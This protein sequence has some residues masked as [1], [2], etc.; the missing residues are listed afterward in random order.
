MFHEKYQE[1]TWARQD[2]ISSSSRA[3]ACG[4]RAVLIEKFWEAFLTLHTEGKRLP[5]NLEILFTCFTIQLH[6]KLLGANNG[7]SFY[8]LTRGM[9]CKAF[10]PFSGPFPLRADVVFYGISWE[11]DTKVK[12]S[13]TK[14]PSV[15]INKAV[16]F[17]QPIAFAVI[18]TLERSPLP[19][20]PLFQTMF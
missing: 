18:C 11:M 2:S 8:L 13:V 16:L 15:V 9:Y 6:I 10:L 19:L 1:A 3:E 14:A 17:F 7:V 4:T 5:V 20:P 12:A